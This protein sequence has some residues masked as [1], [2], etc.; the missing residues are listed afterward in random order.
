MFWNRK[1][2]KKREPRVKL[3]R[4]E[5]KQL[6]QIRARA[7]R[8]K[9]PQTAQQTIPYLQMYPDGVCRVTENRYSRTVRYYDINYRQAQ[10]SDQ[11]AIFSGWGGVLN[12]FQPDVHVQYSFINN[13]M[14]EAEFDH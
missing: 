6:A 4:A 7:Q 10:K 3:S 2:E 11:Q 12:I 14:S 8:P 9:Y 13:Q 5:K 1:K